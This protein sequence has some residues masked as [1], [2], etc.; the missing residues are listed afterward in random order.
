M[1]IPPPPRTSAAPRG[2][3]ALAWWRLAVGL[4]IA[5]AACT[6]GGARAQ[7]AETLE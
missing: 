6:S 4:L 7:T 2:G 5:L 1:S 3:A